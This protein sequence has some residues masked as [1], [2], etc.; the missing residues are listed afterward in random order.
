[1]VTEIAHQLLEQNE[2]VQFVGLLDGWATFSNA[3]HDIHHAE[4]LKLHHQTMDGTNLLPGGVDNPTLWETMLQQRLRLMSSYSIKRLNIELTL[5]KAKS[6]L[7]EY[8]AINHADNH[9]SAHSSIPIQCHSVPGDH[10]TMLQKHNVAALAEK[11]QAYLQGEAK[12][13]TPK[14]DLISEEF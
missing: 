6:I 1:M 7:Q 9:W 13:I 11:I 5:F 2:Q 3:Q 12:P 4:T 8:Q 10:N 14:I